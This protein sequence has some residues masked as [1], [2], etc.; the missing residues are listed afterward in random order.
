MRTSRLFT[1]M[2]LRVVPLFLR[3]FELVRFMLYMPIRDASRCY[4]SIQDLQNEIECLWVVWVSL[5]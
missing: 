3:A 2:I 5:K 1:R 4:L